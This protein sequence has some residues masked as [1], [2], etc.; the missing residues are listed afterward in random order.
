MSLPRAT[1]PAFDAIPGLLH[2]FELRPSP[3]TPETR[4]RGR[5]RV[6][7][8]LASAGRVLFLKQVHGVEVCVGPWDGTPEA[9]GAVATRAGLLLAV[10][11]ADC[12]PLLLVDPARRIVGVTHA[13]WRGTTR[14]GRRDRAG[15]RHR[16]R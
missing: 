10:E 13:G 2:G 9:D 12:V 14:R 8:E 5:G 3:R 7:A 6:A 11:T 1:V 4:E 16:E 15:R